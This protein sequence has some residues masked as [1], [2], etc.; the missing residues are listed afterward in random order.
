MPRNARTVRD[1]GK[2]YIYALKYRWLTP[3]YDPI[4]RLTLREQTFK[5]ALV[6]QARIQPG[7]CV[8]DLGCGT[9]TLT[10]LIKSAHPHAHVVG[11]DGDPKILS[12]AEAKAARAGLAVDWK[13]GL[14]QELPYADSCFDRVLSSLMLHHLSSEN[15]RAALR[16]VLRVLR[17]GG[18]LHVA[19]WGRP[20]NAL[21]R[22]ASLLI[23]LLDGYSRENVEGLLPELFRQAGLAE[24]RQAAHYNT[25]FGT[26]ALYSARKPV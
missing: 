14:A 1:A 10:L 4:L 9:G 7:Q 15:K 3:L 8:L 22:P 24:A 12:L 2:E 13:Q 26:L 6:E 18:E 5:K 20:Q 19:D 17:P 16:E 25:L 21:M 11:F 23:A